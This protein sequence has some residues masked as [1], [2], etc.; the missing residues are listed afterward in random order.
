MTTCS[1][2]PHGCGRSPTTP[3]EAGACRARA[4]RAAASRTSSTWP[5]RCST[6]TRSAHALSHLDRDPRAARRGR[7]LGAELRADTARSRPALRARHEHRRR[8]SA[9]RPASTAAARPTRP[10]RRGSTT[11][12]RRRRGEQLTRLAGVR[13]PARDCRSPPDAV[14]PRPAGASTARSAEPTTP[15][16]PR[17]RAGL[18]H[19]LGVAELLHEL[20]REPGPR[21]G[22]GRARAARRERLADGHAHRPRRV[23]RL[24]RPRRAGRARRARAGAS[25]SPRAR[26]AAGSLGRPPAALAHPRRAGCD[27]LAARGSRAAR[28]R[29]QRRRGATRCS[30]TSRWLYPAGGDWIA[31]SA[32][33]SRRE[34]ELL[35]SPADGAPSSPA[36]ALCSSTARRPRGRAWRRCSRAEVDQVYLQHDLSIVA[37]GRSRRDRRPAARHRR[38]REPRARRPATGSPRQ[39]QPRPGR[40][41]DA[42]RRSCEFL[43]VDLA[44]RHPAAARLPDLRARRPVRHAAGRDARRRR[45]TPAGAGAALRPLRRRRAASARSPSTRPRPARPAPSRPAPDGQP[46]RRRRACSGR[47]AT[48]A[49]RSP[50]RTPTASSCTCARRRV[51]HAERTRRPSTR[52]PAL[53]ATAARP[54]PTPRRPSQRLARPAARR[55]PIRA[56]HTLTVSVRMPGG[57]DLGLP[58]RAGQRRRRPPAGARPPRRHRAHPAALQ[59]RAASPPLATAAAD[60]ARR[61]RPCAVHRQPIRRRLDGY[62]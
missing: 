26:R 48:P 7:D 18:R 3:L 24:P 51:A 2:S 9:R 17:R 58:A 20:Q 13:L 39:R 35:G 56:K 30:T 31:S 12:T 10:A 44:H 47:S 59:H 61:A 15:R 22:Q 45:P 50:P 62:V 1:R 11:G 42:P 8:R 14:G 55:S 52:P 60:A 33:T 6:P 34:A 37:P 21:T 46:V 5:R 53:V 4:R 36:G 38:R 40:R 27:A 54:E 41:R 57:D 32:S 25:G 19:D 43:V 16:P 28:Q 49:T 23:S 29:S